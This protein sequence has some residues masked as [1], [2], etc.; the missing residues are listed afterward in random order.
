ML[1]YLLQIVS[2]KWQY[3]LADVDCPIVGGITGEE[4]YCN[5]LN[6]LVHFDLAYQIDEVESP[7]C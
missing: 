4:V 5:R 7:A 2:A 6:R 1:V 3:P